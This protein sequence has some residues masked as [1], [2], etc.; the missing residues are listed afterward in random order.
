M[1][2]KLEVIYDSKP[3]GGC[4]CNCGCEGSSKVEDM[5]ELLKNLTEYKFNTDVDFNSF[6]IDENDTT[7]VLNKINNILE[8]TDASF[9]LDEGNLEDALSELLPMVVLEGKVIVAYGIP[10]LDDVVNKVQDNT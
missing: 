5:D 6:N 9:R 8:T 3:S 7:Q 4:G 2:K 1:S 10:T